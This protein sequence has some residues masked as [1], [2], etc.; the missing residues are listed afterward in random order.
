MKLIYNSFYLGAVLALFTFQSCDVLGKYELPEEGSIEDLT[1]PNASFSYE[2]GAGAP[3]AWKIYTFSNEST[4]STGFSWDFGD[5]NTSTEVEPVNIYP[6]EGEFTATLVSTDDLGVE[7]T[8]SQIITIVEPEEPVAAD[9]VLINSDFDKIPKSTGSDCACSAWINR[10]LGAQGESTTSNGNS[11]LRFDNDEHD[12]I[13]QEFAVVPNTDYTIKSV[14]GFDAFIGGSYPSV[15]ETRILAGSGYV[16][17]YTPTYYLE[18][19]DFPQDNFGYNSITQVEDANN[20]LLVKTLNHPNTTS[21]ITYE[22]TFNSGANTSVA[23]FMRGIG[24]DGTPSDD[25]G[26]LYNSGDEEIQIDS[27]TIIANTN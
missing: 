23:L 8:F 12:A 3:D 7:S 17:G 26:L 24:G 22:Y 4:S 21:Y 15:L 13:Y 20:N 16:N 9:P 10:S 18:G 1:P 14:I 5:G 27:V 19:K 2:Q 11:V 6:G 25:K